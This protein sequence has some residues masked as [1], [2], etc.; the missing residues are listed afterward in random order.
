MAHPPKQPGSLSLCERTTLGSFKHPQA[1]GAPIFEIVRR[2]NEAPSVVI[3]RKSSRLSESSFL[4]NNLATADKY[5]LLLPPLLL[6]LSPITASSSHEP[7]K[8]RSVASASYC[9]HGPLQ[10]LP[11]WHRSGGQC[12]AETILTPINGQFI[13]VITIAQAPVSGQGAGEEYG[14]SECANWIL[15]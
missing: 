6:F 8:L 9:I 11:Y 14:T 15:L 2:K 3:N 10:L 7:G 5:S 4:Y 12:R 1:A 13:V